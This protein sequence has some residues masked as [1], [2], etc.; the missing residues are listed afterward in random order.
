MTTPERQDELVSALQ[1]VLEDRTKAEADD[2][3]ERAR[4][5]A[6][7]P[8]PQWPAVL[9]L[10]AALAAIGW[11]WTARPAVIFGPGTH[12]PRT[13][14]AR[15]A[16]LRFALYL[17]HARVRQHV[18]TQGR[19]PASLAEAGPV[20]EGVTLEA[21]GGEWAVRGVVDGTTLVLTDRMDADSFLGNAVQVLR[22]DQ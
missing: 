19:V 13:A 14:D 15:V 11:I 5:R 12:P 2:R 4:R 20:E 22:E 18:A 21:A 10:V 9:V 8:R 3:A 1:A 6:G 7:R 16:R 17:Q